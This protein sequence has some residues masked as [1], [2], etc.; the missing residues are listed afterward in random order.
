VLEVVE[1][2][3]AST[4]LERREFAFRATAANLTARC[5]RADRARA[6]LARLGEDG[7]AALPRSSTWLTGMATIAEAAYLVG[8]AELATE[9]GALLRPFA[10]LP[11]MPSL[12]V[13]CLGS[14]ERA[15]GL[16]ALG[17]GDAASAVSHS[18]AAAAANLR[19]ENHPMAAMARADL[20]VALRRRGLPATPRRATS[21]RRRPPP[22]PRP[23]RCR[24]G[25][26]VEGSGG[27][28]REHPR[29]ELGPARPTGRD[30]EAMGGPAPHASFRRRGR[31]CS[32]A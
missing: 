19:L 4:T 30:P 20:A 18:I 25:E 10:A 24:P 7:L 14:A 22:R 1:E 15:L 27:R 32:C 23:A 8:D 26:G 11:V 17:A 31:G 29:I 16:A 3:A 12:G 21:P 28:G 9:A 6:V 5:G 2:A 13:V